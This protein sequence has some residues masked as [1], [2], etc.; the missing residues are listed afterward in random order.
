[1]VKCR[2]SVCRRNR[3]MKSGSGPKERC[4]GQ[5]SNGHAG[6]R[7]DAAAGNHHIAPIV[8][9]REAMS[10]QPHT[11]KE[12]QPSHGRNHP[13]DEPF[14][15]PAQKPVFDHGTP[16]HI[17][18]RRCFLDA[19]ADMNTG[20][21]NLSKTMATSRRTRRLTFVLVRSEG[22]ISDQCKALICS[23]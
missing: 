4:R 6:F 12:G 10:G 9:T 19:V 5:L 13:L 8:L 20:F 18:W 7:A 14:W 17:V 1:M 16:T 15:K 21:H 22:S 3:A 11:S 2:A 23:G